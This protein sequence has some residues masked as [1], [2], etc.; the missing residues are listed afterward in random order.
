MAPDPGGLPAIVCGVLTYFLLPNRPA[1]AAFLTEHEK[2]W[3][4][5]ELARRTLE[6]QRAI[7]LGDARI[8]SLA[9][10]AS[11]LHLFSE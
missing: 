8:G 1:D 10:V 5:A 3:I 11:G 4:T 7:N 6:D 9:G 2:G